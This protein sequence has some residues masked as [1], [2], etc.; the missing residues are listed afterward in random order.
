MKAKI[1]AL[2]LV[3]TVFGTAAAYAASADTVADGV[4]TYALFEDA[5]EHA[6]LESCPAGFDDE[7]VFCRLTL[8]NEQA[9]VFVFSYDG[10]QPL[11]AIKAFELTEAGLSF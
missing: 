1:I 6:D 3:S 8:A 10:D 4:L 11:V 7:T 9:H 5:V 2:T